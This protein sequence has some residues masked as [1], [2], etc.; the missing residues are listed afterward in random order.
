M[1]EKPGRVGGVSAY[2]SPCRTWRYSLTREVSPEIGRGICTFVG[3]NPSTADETLDDPTIR[4]CISFARDWGYRQLK[5]VNLYAFRATN[6]HEMMRAEDPVGPENDLVLAE[7]FSE[8]DLIVACWG[9]HAGDRR[10]RE[11]LAITGRSLMCLGLNKSGTPKHPLYIRRD[12]Q[13]RE[14]PS[15]GSYIGDT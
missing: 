1:E 10:V 5:M 3:L 2:L 11:V 7:A 12:T 15:P 6:P 14:F 13:L 4:R 8:S 9:N